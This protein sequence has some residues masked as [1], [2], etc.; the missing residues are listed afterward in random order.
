MGMDANQTSAPYH[1]RRIGFVTTSR[2][3]SGI[4][5]S[6]IQALCEDKQREPILFAGGTH[7]AVA[8]G[9][10]IDTLPALR[11]LRVIPVHH[12]VEG[13]RPVDVAAS[14]GRAVDAF[15]RAFAEERPDLLFVLGDRAEMLAAA[16]AAA[17]HRIPM[18]HLHGG[19]ATAGAY[20]DAC[21]HAITKFAHV[22]F[23]SLP[24]YAERLA[25]MNEDIRRIHVVGAPA[26]DLL[27]AFKPMNVDELSAAVGL[28][29]ARDSI[30]VAFH[31]ETLA[32]ITPEAQT[33][34]LLSG[35]VDTPSNLLFIGAN[36]DVG[37]AAVTSAIRDFT[38][39]RSNARWIPSLPRHVFWSAMARA[40]ALIGNSSAGII[41]A[42][43]FRLPVVNIGD[44]QVGRIRA[45]NVIDVP[46]DANAIARAVARAQSTEFA[47]S[48]MELRNPYGDGHAT[49]RMLA[50]IQSLPAPDELIR[51]PT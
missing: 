17:I 11:R 3:D 32:T 15:S 31:P 42:A 14:V 25:A 38:S 9:R 18:A 4:Y 13:D 5:E 49:K 22:H 41:E 23:A 29:F 10:T 50:V 7:H 26:L 43:S 48:L 51:K 1:Y 40:R 6:I 16:L 46:F 8:F 35:L 2:A 37:R 33:A 34:A 30:V 24:E 39:H 44:R 36:A 19:E 27:C 21:R 20:D 45:L 28:D 47:A 12:H